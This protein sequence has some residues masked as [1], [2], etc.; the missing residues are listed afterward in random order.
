MKLQVMACSSL[1]FINKVYSVL[2]KFETAELYK[3]EKIPVTGQIVTSQYEI[4]MS[5]DYKAE[6]IE[7]HFVIGNPL[8]SIVHF[9]T[10]GV[11]QAIDEEQL[12]RKSVSEMQ[13][14]GHVMPN[15][16]IHMGGMAHGKAKGTG[17]LCF[18]LH[19]MEGIALAGQSYSVFYEHFTKV[20]EE[21]SRI[22]PPRP[23]PQNDN[24]HDNG[25]SGSPLPGTSGAS[26]TSGTNNN[27]TNTNT[28]AGGDDVDRD[29]GPGRGGRC[30]RCRQSVSN[31]EDNENNN[32]VSEHDMDKEPTTGQSKEIWW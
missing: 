11:I 13:S 21:F 26:G 12:F 1:A 9:M 32:A 19:S 25:N 15:S 3:N 18:F 31:R 2:I 30:G 27:N 4:P 24:G 22:I 7:S 17:N 29:D 28:N 8:R 6:D 16:D 20:R 10:W 23:N 14:K 5:G